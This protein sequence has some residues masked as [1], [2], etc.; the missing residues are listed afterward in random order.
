[1]PPDPTTAVADVP[2]TDE[3]RDFC[4]RHDLADHL[5]RAI[6]LARQCFSIVGN[7]VVQ[8]EED[9]EDGEWYL[10]LEVRVR[11]EED[12]CSRAH[13]AYNR[14]WANSTP[15]PAVHMITLIVDLIEE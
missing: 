2:L 10:V 7:P 14:S 9:P 5:G 11:G 13:K 6:E 15:R 8:L 12:E 3:V 4:R 1:M